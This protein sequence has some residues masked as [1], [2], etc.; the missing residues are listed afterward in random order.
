MILDL[1]FE[2]FSEVDLPAVGLDVYSAHPSTRVLMCA[3]SF[4]DGRDHLWTEEDGPFPYE[5]A[6]ALEDPGVEKWAFNMQFERTIANRVLGLKVPIQNSRCVQALAYMFSFFG[7]LDAVGEQ[8]GMPQDMQKIKGGKR[9]ID[10][11]CRPQKITKNQPYLLR[12]ART[13]PALWD[14]FGEYC[15]GDNRTEK[16]V[17]RQLLK[18]PL[19]DGEWDIYEL[20]QRINDRGFPMDMQFVRAA[21]DMARRRQAELRAEMT[22]LSGVA[23]PG[24]TQQLLPWLRERGYPFNDLQKD[25]IKAV[26]NGLEESLY[27]VESEAVEMMRLRQLQAQTSVRKFDTV[28]KSVGAQDRLRFSLQYS[29]ASRTRRWAGRKW[30]SQNLKRTPKILE[31]KNDDTYWIDLATNCIREDRYDD[32]QVHFGEPMD[33]LSGLVRSSIR[34]PDGEELRVS[35]LA[36]IETVGLAWLS[37]NEPVLETFRAGRDPY[38]AFGVDW[39]HVAY[40][41]ITSAQRTICKPAVLGCGYGL[42]G[43][44][45]REGKKTGLWGYAENMGVYMTREEAI[46][47]VGVWRSTNSATVKFWKD[48]ENAFAFALRGIKTK[49]GF[50]TFEYRKPFLIMWLPGESP[51]YYYQPR[52]D[53]ETVKPRDGEEYQRRVLSYMGKQQNGN[54]WIRVKTYGGKIAENATQA[55]CRDVLGKGMVRADR[56]GFILIGHSHDEGITLHPRGDNYHTYQR[57]SEVLSEAQPE[58]PGLPLR[59]AGYSAQFYRKD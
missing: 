34:A 36:S 44:G 51:R 26:L 15:L 27:E 20:D 57:L 28:I 22:E 39:L 30:Q 46:S 40:D 6:E 42:G 16:G 21:A 2:T 49:V 54:S 10:I 19:G 32:L 5:L 24:S 59:A 43:G 4:D 8:M 55:F 12:S 37:G 41:E 53:Y 38:R 35:D 58:Y 47:A 3:Y 17:K 56:D 52:V 50:L 23:N 25:T 33:M 13:D 48:L 18:F 29:G 9:L 7:G 11:F 31:V 1:D 14:E 45:L